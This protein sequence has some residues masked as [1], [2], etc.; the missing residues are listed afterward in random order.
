MGP[1][2]QPT[3]QPMGGPPHPMDM[4]PQG[5]TMMGPQ[6]GPGQ[7]VGPPGPMGPPMGGPNDQPPMVNGM[8]NANGYLPGPG[9]PESDPHL[10]IMQQQQPEW[11]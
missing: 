5:H 9:G 1:M 3:M 11:T 2:G 10:Q 8:I 7:M 6:V 4:V